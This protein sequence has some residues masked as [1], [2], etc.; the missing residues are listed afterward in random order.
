MKCAKVGA[1][2]C[3]QHWYGFKVLHAV[4]ASGDV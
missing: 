2:T 3:C 1:E 4:S